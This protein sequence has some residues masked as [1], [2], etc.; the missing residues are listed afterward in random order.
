M[1]QYGYINKDVLPKKIKLKAAQ[2]TLKKK[3]AALQDAK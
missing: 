1:E 3:E 2:E